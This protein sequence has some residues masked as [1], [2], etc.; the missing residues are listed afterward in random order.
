[1]RELS[2]Y[3]KVGQSKHQ[4]PIIS[5]HAA[6]WEGEKKSCISRLIEKRRQQETKFSIT[7]INHSFQNKVICMSPSKEFS[8][9]ENTRTTLQPKRVWG[10]K[11]LLLQEVRYLNASPLSKIADP[12]VHVHVAQ[13]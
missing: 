5:G 12:F 10:E 7:K 9:K 8:L 4:T 11:K 3:L 2:L 1:M 13:K 6:T